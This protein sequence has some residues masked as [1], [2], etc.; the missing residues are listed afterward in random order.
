MAM[1]PIQNVISKI[2][3]FSFCERKRKP[4]FGVSDESDGLLNSSSRTRR[5]ENRKTFIN[6][7]K[8]VNKYFKPWNLSIK[9]VLLKE[10]TEDQQTLIREINLE[11]E[12]NDI[13][14]VIDNKRKISFDALILKVINSFLNKLFVKKSFPLFDYL[15]TLYI[16]LG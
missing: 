8:I 5:F 7:L 12:K 15:L 2:K 14:D 10:G 6:D 11:I 16:F 4:Y 1:Q 3:E 9:S 13:E